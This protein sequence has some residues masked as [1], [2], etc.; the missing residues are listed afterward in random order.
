MGYLQTHFKRNGIG[1]GCI[2]L[3]AKV[4]YACVKRPFYSV[5]RH[6]CRQADPGVI[7]FESKPDFSDNARVLFSYMQEKMPEKYKIVWLVEDP[8]KYEAYAGKTVTFIR[9]TTRYSERYTMRATLAAWRAGTIFFTHSLYQIFYKPQGQRWINLWHGCGYKAAKGQ[10]EHICFDYC[11][12]PGKLFIE[13]KAAFFACE[14][15]KLLT[16]GYPRY[17]LLLSPCD[18]VRHFLTEKKAQTS[19]DKVI[20]WMPTY[21]KTEDSRFAEHIELGRYGLPFIHDRKQMKQ[22]NHWCRQRRILLLIK[23]H[24]METEVVEEQL[25][26][27]QF[28]QESDLEMAGIQLYE[29][30]GQTDALVTDYSSVAVDYMLCDKPIAFL[31]EDYETYRKNRG[32]VFAD[33]LQYMP[34]YHVRK[35]EELLKF[36]DDIVQE[37]DIY[38]DMRQSLMNLMHNRTN[39]YCGRLLAHLNL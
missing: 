38:R 16:L 39:D 4:I 31:L 11:L 9:R 24:M 21:R 33:P 37:S 25:T 32:F 5:L 36:L 28:I 10:S 27:V 23:H 1:K 15:E 3:V 6:F 12:V 13:S 20:I 19:T 18:R 8:G 34:G 7:L 29:L 35:A 14:K 2:M 22:L 17:D 30:L 26:C